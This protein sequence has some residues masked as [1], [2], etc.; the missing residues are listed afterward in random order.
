MIGILPRKHARAGY[1]AR[2]G[3]SAGTVIPAIPSRPARAL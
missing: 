3:M 1:Q 2:R